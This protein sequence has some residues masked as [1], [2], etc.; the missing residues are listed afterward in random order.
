MMER[1]I[2]HQLVHYW[3]GIKGDRVL[4]SEADIDPEE[5]GAMWEDCFLI[6]LSEGGGVDEDAFGSYSHIGSNLM[7]IF[8]EVYGLPGHLLTLP[9]NHLREAYQEMQM[10]KLP[11]VENVDEFQM[12]SRF[13]QYRQCLL[14]IGTEKGEIRGIFGGMRYRYI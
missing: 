1:R 7:P 11:I 10:T 6:Y 3:Q 9:P 14:P 8:V 12:E 5:L 13:I 2:S 4:P